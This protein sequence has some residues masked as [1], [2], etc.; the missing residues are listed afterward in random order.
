MNIVWF[1]R[2]LRTLD[3]YPL[4]K[5]STF[6]EVLPLYII[7]P[8]VW[9]KGNLSARH[10]EYV[11]ESLLDLAG[12]IEELGGTLF[13]AYGDAEEI[14]ARIFEENGPFN[15]FF[16]SGAGFPKPD[17]F[18]WLDDR[19]VYYVDYPSS[20]IE[21]NQPITFKKWLAEISHMKV[22]TP[23]KI[24]MANRIPDWLSSS[25]SIL[26]RVQPE[27]EFI[28]FGQ[29]GGEGNAIETLES[30]LSDRHVK[31]FS[32]KNSPLKESLYSSRLSPY[33]AWGNISLKFV[34]LGTVKLLEEN[35]PLS[36]QK[37]LDAFLRN[38]YKRFLLIKTDLGD[39]Q[40]NSPVLWEGKKQQKDYE[41]LKEG[42]T[43]IPI[44][45]ASITCLMKTGWLPFVLRRLVAF[46]AINCVGLEKSRVS[47]LLGSL[48][49][50]Y[51]PPIH[52]DQIEMAAALKGNSNYF[53][54]VRAGRKI[55]PDG[56]FI[57][58][59]L[60]ELEGLPERYIHEPWLFPGFFRL[61]YPAPIIDPDQCYKSL[62]CQSDVL[63]KKKDLARS[64][65][66]DEDSHGQLT[67]NLFS[68]F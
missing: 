25:S 1:R 68:E 8:T 52:E 53:H 14:F 26:N 48:S 12:S 11:K 15:L 42:R 27:G 35:P 55:N 9:K 39:R 6:G 51:D 34:V 37:A 29:A 30:F 32:A 64:T 19:G 5:A 17:F 2:D 38:L 62:S 18:K 7:E 28:R 65:E 57:K 21:G 47:R 10:Y 59:F 49:L 23:I 22:T 54:I 61:G 58:R 33:L 44:I 43:G 31:Y 20:D 41:S 63:D 45:D 13:I 50:D 36:Q 67:F 16:H 60:P 56:S 46:F 3:H 40:A 4:F 24:N 66:N